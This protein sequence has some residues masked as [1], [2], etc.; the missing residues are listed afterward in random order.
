MA[1]WAS[2]TRDDLRHASSTAGF[3]T[4]FPLLV[5][6]LILETCPAVTELDMPG[7]SG[8]AGGGF[9][10]VVVNGE[11]TPWVPG[12]TSVWELSVEQSAKRKANHDYAKRLSAPASAPTGEVTYVSAIL[13]PWTGAREWASD[14]T[15]DG[16][17]AAVR[18]LNLDAI[19][20][21]LES[22]PA[23]SAWLASELGK[24]LP[25]VG[26]LDRWWSGSWLP[27]TR[28]PLGPEVL[29]AGRRAEADSFIALLDQ[30]ERVVSLGGDLRGDEFLA[31]V[32]A[33]LTS[34]DRDRLLARTVYVEDSAALTRILTQPRP[35]ILLLPE[36]GL[37]RHAPV[38]HE[39][40]LVLLA[41]HESRVDIALPR[42]DSSAVEAHFAS[43]GIPT[44]QSGVLGVLA[45]RSISALRRA[46]ALR[47]EIL[48]PSWAANPDL[49]RRRLLLIGGWD[50]RF[51]GDRQ[52]LSTYF[53]R[54]YEVIEDE[55]TSLAGKDD[56][57]MLEQVDD[58]WHLLAPHDA[59]TLLQE[60][61]TTHD[62]A[63][64]AEIC[65][66][67]LLERDPQFGLSGSARFSAQFEG[68][69]RKHS[70]SLRIGL[71]QALALLGSTRDD[72]PVLRNNSASEWA[73]RIAH[74][75]L[76]AAN[77]DTTYSTWSALSGLLSLL[78]EA[79]PDSFLAAMRA[80]LE[81]E[82]PLHSQMFQDGANDEF[83]SPPQSPHTEFLWALETLAWSPE[84]FGEVVDVLGDLAALDPGGKWSNRPFTS[85]CEILSL[86]RPNTQADFEQ[87][88][89]AASRLR[90]AHPSVGW[91][92]LVDL[93]PDGHGFQTD[94]SGPHFRD[95]KKRQTITWAGLADAVDRVAGELIANLGDDPER[96]LQLLDRLPNISPSR[97]REYLARLTSLG[98]R[99][100]DD[101]H[102]GELHR[103][104]S[105]LA[106]RHREYSD[107]EWSLPSEDVE[108]LE[109]SAR[110]LT[111]VGDL[112]R[113]R[114]VFAPEPIAARRRWRDNYEEYFREVAE[115]RAAAVRTLFDSRGVQGVLE[116]AERIDNPG[117]VGRALAEAR[118]PLDE[119]LRADLVAGDPARAVASQYFSHRFLQDGKGLLDQVLVSATGNPTVQARAL[120]AYPDHT[121]AQKTLEELSAEVTERYWLEFSSFWATKSDAELASVTSGLVGVG[122]NAAALD[123]LAMHDADSAEFAATAARAC[124]QLLTAHDVDA[125][126][127][128]LQSY[129][130]SKIVALL[131]RHRAYLGLDRVVRI[132][133]GL[134]PALGFDA[135]I[136]TLND[137]MAEDPEFFVSIVKL[138]FR[139]KD[140][141]DQEVMPAQDE[142]A[143][144][145]ARRAYSALRT[146][147]RVPGSD[148]SGAISP[149][150]LRGW[151]TEARRLLRESGR[152]QVGDHEIGQVLAFAQADPDGTYPPRAV[153]EL[154]EETKSDDLDSGIQ[155]G[156]FN[157]RGVTSRG[158]TDGGKQERDLAERYE[159][160]AAGLSR[161][162][163]A[164]RLFREIAV[165]YRRDA[166]REDLEAERRMRGVD[167]P[168][169]ALDWDF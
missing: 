72:G 23:T 126:W 164:R 100:V 76:D 121:L 98:H 52:A 108:A 50:G 2:L 113:A 71:A 134:L 75:I 92:L 107:A 129:D 68:R 142:V 31:F 106:A 11:A 25:G 156:H 40:Q 111:P 162:P 26:A 83:G 112:E 48:T 160:W 153:C 13:A 88:F 17:W 49:L 169:A 81:G 44:E 119:A 47:P 140:Q 21:W 147:R 37:A 42:V 28:L 84:Y 58:H 7:G 120:L 78:A 30:D 118:V 158:L 155:V 161:W 18:A 70:R 123:L 39:H 45:R 103:A 20:A 116:L 124:E 122:R 79:S 56:L 15:R 22:A 16:R 99:L 150:G 102:R 35:L 66:T 117:E 151:V 43:A 109:T 86:W 69:A 64:F 127:H 97:R 96:Y 65:R 41:T 46:L 148:E 29:L 82:D 168:L 32:A 93:I 62:F 95:W 3:D 159:E 154:V 9:D 55:A 57:P 34:A 141:D 91:R 73:A 89:A 149:D 125:E 10:G 51:E 131:Y 137:A 27:S 36:S 77:R 74:E 135:K 59:W 80:G 24:T 130:I 145:Q 6:R 90:N 115:R 163:R 63:S 138:A 54:S 94:H 146:W 1:V 101:R 157:K 14:R 67:V 33:A 165:R 60:H 8:V 133:W 166:E 132:E 85:L 12:G 38:H 53:G 167:T 105:E 152:S 110:A 4:V 19:H 144:A 128:Q 139:R 114:L 104:V 5:R 87:R 143:Q 136:P 61:L